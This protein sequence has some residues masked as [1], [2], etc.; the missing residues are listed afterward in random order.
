MHDTYYTGLKRIFYYFFYQNVRAII[1]YR[2]S[3]KDT[4]R[5]IQG[6]QWGER[7]CRLATPA[8][9][10]VLQ[11]VQDNLPLLYLFSQTEL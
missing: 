9:K 10:P 3:R 5:V 8:E 6:F 4:L 7:C 2:I 1:L 11:P